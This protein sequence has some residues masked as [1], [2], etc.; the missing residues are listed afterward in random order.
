MRGDGDGGEDGVEVRGGRRVSRFGGIVS[1]GVLGGV[2][3]L[4]C[5]MVE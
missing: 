2:F 3:V 5:G 4:K 1:R